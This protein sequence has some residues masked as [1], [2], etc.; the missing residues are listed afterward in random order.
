M[1]QT[2]GYTRVLGHAGGGGGAPINPPKTPRLANGLTHC[3]EKLAQIRNCLDSTLSRVDP[4]EGP[5]K[6]EVEAAP[7]S[8]GMSLVHILCALDDLTNGIQSRVQRLDQ[9][10]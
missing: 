3:L 1:D 7:F 5:S 4:N 6:N 9:M 2:T 8:E 10:L